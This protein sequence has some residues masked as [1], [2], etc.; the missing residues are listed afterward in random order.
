MNNHSHSSQ[1]GTMLFSDLLILVLVVFDL[2]TWFR[3]GVALALAGWNLE[4]DQ[5]KDLRELARLTDLLKEQVEEEE[6][7]YWTSRRIEQYG[8]C[9]LNGISARRLSLIG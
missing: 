8:A 7:S 3:R 6:H 2:F 9:R 1:L 4:E 5:V